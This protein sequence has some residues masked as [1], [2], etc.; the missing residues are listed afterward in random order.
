MVPDNP[1]S[2]TIQEIGIFVH[3][4][5]S[6]GSEACLDVIGMAGECGPVFGPILLNWCRDRI[7]EQTTDALPSH[8]RAQLLMA[9]IAP[10]VVTANESKQSRD[11]Y[12]GRHP[13]NHEWL[14]EQE[15]LADGVTEVTLQSDQFLDLLAV[16]RNG[17]RPKAIT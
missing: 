8:V 11:R 10:E 5:T 1:L 4:R 16:A 14:D 2:V 3:F 15:L 17:L 12:S 6:D 7:N 13:I 9:Q